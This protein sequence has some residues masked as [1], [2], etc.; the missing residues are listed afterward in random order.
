MLSYWLQKQS[1]KQSQHSSMLIYEWSSKEFLI[2][3]KSLYI[4]Q[5]YIFFIASLE[6][7]KCLSYSENNSIKGKYLNNMSCRYGHY[8]P[9]RFRLNS[10]VGFS[11]NRLSLLV[12]YYF[13]NSAYYLLVS[14]A[15]RGYILI[16]RAMTVNS[17]SI[18]YNSYFII[19]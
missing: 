1:A 7:T 11:K 8:S 5:L 17:S 15:D 6:L 3:T 19:L 9:Y 16:L 13:I 4:D 12:L 18:F 2:Y 10:V 14:S